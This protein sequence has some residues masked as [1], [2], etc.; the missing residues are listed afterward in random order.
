MN[1]CSGEDGYAYYKKGHVPLDEFMTQLKAYT[2]EIDA[3]RNV[4]P[5]HT[6]K[7]VARDFQA[8]HS[9]VI[10]AKPLSRG[11]FPVTWIELQTS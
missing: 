9:V 1:Y 7:R 2:D 10:N 6:W 4:A 8:G 11:S 3:I 5:I